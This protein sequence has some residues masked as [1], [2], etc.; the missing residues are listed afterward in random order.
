[1]FFGSVVSGS[2]TL[3]C[4]E[5]ECIMQLH[6]GVA[7]GCTHERKWDKC[8]LELVYGDANVHCPKVVRVLVSLR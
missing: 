4:G 7:S 1:M 3:K 6:E 8:L 5:K 2:S